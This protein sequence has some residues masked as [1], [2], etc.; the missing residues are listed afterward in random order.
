MNTI[1]RKTEYTVFIIFFFLG[2]YDAVK[3]LKRAFFHL[4]E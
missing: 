2:I 1:Y 4:S 3:A